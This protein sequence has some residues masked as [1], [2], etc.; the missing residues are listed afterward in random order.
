MDFPF[1]HIME[2]RGQAE[3][4]IPR[5]GF[6]VDPLAL[7]EGFGKGLQGV[8]C[9]AE[10]NQRHDHFTARGVFAFLEIQLELAVVHRRIRPLALD[11]EIG[12]LEGCRSEGREMPFAVV[13]NRKRV[14]PDDHL[15]ERR[16]PPQAEQDD[17]RVVAAL[18]FLEAPDPP[19][20]HRI[21]RAAGERSDDEQSP[22]DHEDQ[23]AQPA[24]PKE[25]AAGR[26]PFQPEHIAAGLEEPARRRE[27]DAAQL[28]DGGE[29]PQDQHEYPYRPAAHLNL[30]LGSTIATITSDSTFPSN[31][32]NAAIVSVPMIT[33][34]SRAMTA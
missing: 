6:V 31:I 9:R 23:R 4:R 14:F 15:I 21:R 2:F 5:A 1:L 32:R 20:G 19:Q 13:A 18:D 17:E 10:G 16:Q 3:V 7:D 30:I 24:E 25:L 26:F 34:T 27:V 29:R 22:A 12:A 28:P 33:G 11:S 8:V